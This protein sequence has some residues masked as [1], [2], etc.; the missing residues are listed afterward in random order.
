MA[1]VAYYQQVAD[2]L[3]KQNGHDEPVRVEIVSFIQDLGGNRMVV[4]RTFWDGTSYVIQLVTHWRQESIFA[5]ELSHILRGD[6]SREVPHIDTPATREYI[7]TATNGLLEQE[8]QKS[9]DAHEH[10]TE[11]LAKRICDAWHL[12]YVER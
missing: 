9:Y 2:K 6:V 1:H 12:A 4:G 11:D 10:E 7:H 8:A 3:M 5:H